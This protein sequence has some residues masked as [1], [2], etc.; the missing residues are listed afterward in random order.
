MS[1]PSIFAVRCDMFGI[2]MVKLLVGEPPSWAAIP[3]RPP[4]TWKKR[5][6]HGPFQAG[7]GRGSC[8]S[9][10]RCEGFG[11]SSLHA[12]EAGL[13][14]EVG[15]PRYRFVR[16]PKGVG[17]E[18]EV[19]QRRLNAVAFLVRRAADGVPHHRYLEAMFEQVT[20]VGLDADV[21]GGARQDDLLDA[22]LAELQHQVV[23][24]RPVD[25][26]R[27]E[28]DRFAVEDVRLELLGE[29]GP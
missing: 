13:S 17:Q 18:P 4:W 6:G 11:S 8:A 9:R 1:R 12:D 26:V 21:P 22:P 29:V 5:S 2:V 15:K 3:R 7:K 27:A 10:C 14:A 28:D 20:Q 23:G 24:G 25:L 16:G 19:D